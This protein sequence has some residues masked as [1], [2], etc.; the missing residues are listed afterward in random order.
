VVVGAGFG[1]PFGGG[2][3]LSWSLGFHALRVPVSGERGFPCN[4][5]AAKGGDRR[6][7]KGRLG[8][9]PPK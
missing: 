1:W 2:T 7:W 3:Q 6:A 9:L 4:V 8:G 5:L